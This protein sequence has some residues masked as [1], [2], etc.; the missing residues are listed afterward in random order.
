M[1]L[2]KHRCQMYQGNFTLLWHNNLLI[3]SKDAELYLSVLQK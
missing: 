3:H 2:L 1:H